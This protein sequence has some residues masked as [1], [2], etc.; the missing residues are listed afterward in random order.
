VGDLFDWA[1][2]LAKGQPTWTD[3]PAVSWPDGS[4]RFFDALGRFEAALASS[5]P[6]ATSPEKLFQGPVA[7]ALAHVGQIAILRRLASAPIKPENYLKADIAT[8]RVGAAQSPPRR[9]FD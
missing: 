6:L 5:E 3:S 4:A 9:E 8:G 2:S 1:V 7:D